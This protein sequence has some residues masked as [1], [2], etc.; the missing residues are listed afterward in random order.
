VAIGD[1]RVDFDFTIE[2]DRLTL[3]PQLE[4]GCMEF[5]CLWAVMVAMP[6]SG[7]ERVE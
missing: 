6:W 3:E 1:Q 4:P 7:M 5:V 2:G